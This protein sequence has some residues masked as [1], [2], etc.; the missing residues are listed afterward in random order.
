MQ[1]SP[2]PV[3]FLTLEEVQAIDRAML[4][5]MAKFM[6]RITVSSLRVIQKIAAELGV[7]A[8]ELEAIQI[9]QW[10]ERDSLIRKEQG[11]LSAFLQWNA[12]HTDLDFEDTRQDLVTSAQLSSHE[13][14]LTRMVISAMQVLST[15]AKDS[16]THIEDLT[17]N[18]IVNWTER[19]PEGM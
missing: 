12:N 14:F 3:Q 2:V 9:V 6:T 5:P 7:H 19:N 4:S 15:I 18:Q 16:Q 1:A 11:S 17:T 8:E 10:V 13:K